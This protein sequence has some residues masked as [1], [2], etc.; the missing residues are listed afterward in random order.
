[1]HDPFDDPVLGR[2]IWNAERNCWVFDAGPVTGRPIP[3]SYDPAD[4]HL[5]P[6]EQG[7]DGVRTCV[8]WVR[9]NEPDA[10]EYM[11]RQLF[12]R[13]MQDWY[14]ED[15]DDGMTPESFREKLHLSGINFYEDQEAR[16]IYDDGGLFGGHGFSLQVNAAG[17]FVAGPDMFG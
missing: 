16:L 5:P 13:W 15:V 12:E 1:M 10:R 17:E 7:W 3:A 9:T 8:R 14:D 4:N 2:V 6:S 11:T